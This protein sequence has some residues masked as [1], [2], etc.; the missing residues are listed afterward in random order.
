M[1]EPTEITFDIVVSGCAASCWHCYVC[2]GPTTFMPT[3]NFEKVCRFV[4]EFKR[5]AQ[6]KEITVY[7]YLDLEPML[8]PE[9]SELLSLVRVAEWFSLPSC[10]P[11]TGMPIAAREDWERVLESYWGA[12]VRQLEF[13]LHGPEEIHNRAVSRKNAFQS[14]REAVRRA[15]RCGFETKLN[16]MVSKP[17][18]GRFRQTMEAVDRNEYDYQRAAIP[19]YAPNE[20]LRRFERH[21]PQL[22]DVTPYQELLQQFCNDEA[23]DGEFWRDIADFTEQSAYRELLS[24]EDTYM[25]YRQVIETLPTWYFVAVG[26]DLDI[27]YGNGLHRTA[28]LGH[29]GRSS[30]SEILDKVLKEHP[31]FAFGGYFPI[32]RLPSPIEVARLVAKPIGDR[33]YQDYD[34][35][36]IHVMWLDQYLMK[37]PPD[38]RFP[39]KKGRP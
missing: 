3:Q 28:K 23:R 1:S 19:H 20:R 37:H 33:I 2:G 7:P 22:R 38:P 34:N 13:T 15:K 27:W 25:T 14:H 11:T 39:T 30:P 8:H 18:L 4:D 24:N 9:I 36:E 5:I 16:L 31:N 21:R 6:A 29:I 35:C 26:P 17:L 10:I 12:G 32:D